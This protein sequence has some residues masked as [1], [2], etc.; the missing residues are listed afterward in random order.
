MGEIYTISTF[1][2][3][4][5]ALVIGIGDFD[6]YR[7]TGRTYV[8]SAECDSGK[9][10][11]EL[12]D[13]EWEVASLIDAFIADEFLKNQSEA[14]YGLTSALFHILSQQKLK[15]GGTVDMVQYPSVAFPKGENFAIPLGILTGKMRLSVSECLMIKIKENLG[16]GIVSYQKL[17]TLEAVRGEGA[18]EWKDV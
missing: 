13:D 15:S 6:C 3:P 14:D 10:Y 18:L 11:G 9:A 8:G 12:P 16:Y 4:Q 2:V 17:A 5:D 1:V 7:R